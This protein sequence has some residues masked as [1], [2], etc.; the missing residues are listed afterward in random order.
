MWRLVQVTKRLA[1]WVSAKESTAPTGRE[2]LS[3][4]GETGEP[5]EDISPVCSPPALHMAYP[6]LTPPTHYTH[7]SA[8]QCPHLDVPTSHL[9][10]IPKSLSSAMYISVQMFPPP[11]ELTTPSSR[12]PLHLAS[13]SVIEF[14]ARWRQ[15]G[16]FC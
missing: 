7:S 15:L 1:L 13:S 8:R 3:I 4:P 11:S 5:L 6:R 16:L 14:N 10:P 12:F 9:L 2:A